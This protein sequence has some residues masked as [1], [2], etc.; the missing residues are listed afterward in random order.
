MHDAPLVRFLERL[1]QLAD[2]DQNL[3][4]GLRLG[5]NERRKRMTIDKGHRDI[6]RPLDL[7][8]VV[9]GADVR[10]PQIGSGPR[11]AIKPLEQF[12]CRLLL[13][14]RRL[15]GDLPLELRVFGQID[16][17][18]RALAERLDDAVTAELL[19]EAAPIGRSTHRALRRDRFLSVHGERLR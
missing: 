7:P 1:C 2:D 10:V 11:L 16:H 17:A 3:P 4:L 15:E 6:V 8:D 18:H 13:E 14:V 19:L 9:D 12:G 5:A